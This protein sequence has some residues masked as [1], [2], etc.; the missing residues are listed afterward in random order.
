MKF[1]QPLYRFTRTTGNAGR[2]RTLVFM[3]VCAL[4]LLVFLIFGQKPWETGVF[5]HELDPKTMVLSHYVSSGLWLAGALNFILL[6]VLIASA[7]WWLGGTHPL[8]VITES[9]RERERWLCGRQGTV[10]WIALL[11]ILLGATWLRAPRLTHS[12]W[13]DEEYGVRRY[14]TGELEPDKKTGELEVDEVDWEETLFLNYKSN[15][16]VVFSLSARLALG[17]RDWFTG[18]EALPYDEMTV[19]LLPLA[20]GLGSLAGV[21][22]FLALAGL[23]R[24]GLAAAALLAIHPWH[25]RYSVEARGYAFMLLFIILAM[26]CLLLATRR[27]RWR[28]WCGYGIFQMLYI[29]SFP[30]SVYV[31]MTLNL[32]V[33]IYL[34]IAQRGKVVWGTQVPR[35]V[36]VNTASAMLFLQVMGPCLEQI[37]F[38]LEKST[39]EEHV[40]G[41]SWIRDTA[42][43]LFIGTR[44]SQVSPE[45]PYDFSL[46]MLSARQPLLMGFT[47]VFLPIVSLIGLIF[48][49][50]RNAAAAT[51]SLAVLLAGAL[52]YLHNAASDHVLHSWYIVFMILPLAMCLMSG[53]AAVAFMLP[54]RMPRDHIAVGLMGLLLAFYA[55]ETRTITSRI[56]YQDRQPFET[57]AKS[58]RGD[59]PRLGD[60]EPET[61]VAVFGVSAEQVR[62]Y[63]PWVEVVDNP[64]ELREVQE[65]AA[66]ENRPFAVVVGGPNFAP[67]QDPELMEYLKSQDIYQEPET[68][69]GL[70]HMFSFDIYRSDPVKFPPQN[71]ASPENPG[72]ARAVETRE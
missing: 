41:W 43:H 67:I 69:W 53:M 50:R 46:E 18:P 54:E 23:P 12:F 21:A 45:F 58:L 24:A 36:V 17:V 51:I 20:A 38:Y 49:F 60:L 26:I 5:A 48:L 29:W 57:L 4:L 64:A 65:Q 30:G 25:L 37:A 22:I 40:L 72:S 39:A 31:A 2:R 34:V 68:I 66:R 6:L 32:G 10:F 63:L 33:L 13:N 70:E 8:P 47:M 14:V 59:L 11:V 42:V 15:N 7:G 16:H 44:L 28:W 19:R 62:S 71:A 52:S 35:L 56:V 55:F 9:A 27:A 3:L 1:L 61:L